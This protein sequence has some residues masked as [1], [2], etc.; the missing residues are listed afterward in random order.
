L[1]RAACLPLR[2]EATQRIVY[3]YREH[4]ASATL[5][6]GS[7]ARA[8]IWREHLELAQFCLDEK[9]RSDLRQACLELRAIEGGKLLLAD[10]AGRN[11]E[12]RLALMSRLLASDRVFPLNLARGLRSWARWRGRHSDA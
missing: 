7:A 1:M 6:G 11:G 5:S 4:E 12:S 10:S 8:R 3:R 9:W 2:F